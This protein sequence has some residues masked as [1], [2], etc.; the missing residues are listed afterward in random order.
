MRFQR[1]DI[2]NVITVARILVAPFVFFLI[3]PES[4][5]LRFLAFV[6]FLIPQALSLA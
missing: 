5:T 2:P 4:A 6:L 1:S 3:L